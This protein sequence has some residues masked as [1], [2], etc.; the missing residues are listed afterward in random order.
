MDKKMYENVVGC[1]LQKQAGATADVI[2]SIVGGLPTMLIGN[3]IAPGAGRVLGTAVG[4][5]AGLIGAA[6]PASPEDVKK[7]NDTPAL[8]FIPGVGYYRIS[9][10]VQG[11]AKKY[12]D[13]APRARALS[14]EL[15]PVTSTLLSTL[16]G[17]GIGAT[18]SL[19]T[20][21]PKDIIRGG[22][23]GGLTGATAA[24]IANL[25]GALSAGITP[26]RTDKEQKDSGRV[27]QKVM[28]YLV[29]GVATYDKF[30]TLGKSNEL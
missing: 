30:K 21:E 5:G 6:N 2:G 25:I 3:S 4:R 20:G 12:G 24:S 1:V 28:N 19:I 14:T 8:S 13:K 7:F 10:R 22:I 9:Q 29:P 26:R 16:I 17:S 27:S 18:T 23:A 15:G 11:T